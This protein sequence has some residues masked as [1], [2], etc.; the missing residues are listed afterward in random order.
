[1]AL[2]KKV[3]SLEFPCEVHP[4]SFVRAHTLF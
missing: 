1:M 4:L 2:G 3:L